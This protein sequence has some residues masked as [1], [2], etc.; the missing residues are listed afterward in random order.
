VS[1]DA[2]REALERLSGEAQVIVEQY[3]DAIVAYLNRPDFPVAYLNRPDFPA[4]ALE[5][6]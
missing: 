6:E 2:I 3:M 1:D 4:D 5:V